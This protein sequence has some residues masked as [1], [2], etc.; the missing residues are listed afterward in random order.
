MGKI[1]ILDE[2]TANKIAAGEVV[3]RPASI[4]K[5]LCENSIDAGATSIT[6]E[7]K[8]GGIS[9]IKV[10]DNGS[11]ILKDDVEIAFEKHATSKIRS[12]TDLHSVVTMG[13]R[14]EALA[15]IA[16]VAKV[17]LVTKTMNEPEGSKVEIQG[18]A[19][20]TKE[21]VGCPIGTNIIVRDLFFNTPARYKFLKK[22]YTEAGYV[23]DV[24]TRLALANPEI[25]FRLINNGQ[26]VIHSPGNSDLLSTAFAIFGNVAKSTVKVHHMEEGVEIKGIAGKPDTARSNRGQETFF[27]NGRYIKN[28]T[29]A[30]AVEEAYKT[31]IPAGKYPFAILNVMINPQNVDVNVHP[32]KQEVR[33]S[34]ENVIFRSVYHALKNAL[35]E[36]PD[37]IPDFTVGKSHKAEPPQ[38]TMDHYAQELFEEMRDKEP[39]KTIFKPRLDFGFSGNNI[40]KEDQKKISDVNLYVQEKQEEF[41]PFKIIGTVFSTYIIVEFNNEM[42]IIDQ[43][44]AHERVMYEK[45]KKRMDLGES[46]SQMLFIPEVIELTHKEID[47][48]EQNRQAIAKFGFTFENFGNQ[49]IKVNS[50]PLGSY[51]GSVKELFLEVVDGLQE[52]SKKEGIEKED[53]MLYRIACKSAVKANAGLSKE[54]IS[55]LLKS[56]ESV[57]NPYTCPHGRPTTIKMSQKEIEKRFLRT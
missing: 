27:I 21:D 40:G 26:V 16:A 28:K 12:E 19:I 32:T 10:A 6:V 1:V 9:Y 52:L 11:G 34:D 25:S 43:H 23:E 51:K 44:A 2:H 45:L 42:Y 24:V 35:F 49:T 41:V 57:E 46:I 7:I 50:V 37:L 8:N 13:F 22:D 15:S 53:G 29:V 36:G 38:R 33:F 47:M 30:A 39:Q 31:L 17:T 3:E 5:E 48:I 18:G 56:M 20:V 4:V 54:E 14:G 55:A